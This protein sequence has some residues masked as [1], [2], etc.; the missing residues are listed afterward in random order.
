MAEADFSFGVAFFHLRPGPKTF[1]KHPQQ[2][3]RCIFKHKI[4]NVQQQKIKSPFQR[5][6]SY[7]S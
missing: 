4:V 7:L 2:I 5:W 3:M 1:P 6:A